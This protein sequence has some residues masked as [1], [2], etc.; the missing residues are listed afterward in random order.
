MKKVIIETFEFSE[1]SEEAQKYAIQ[2]YRDNMEVDLV[3]FDDQAE[4]KINHAGFENTKLQYR[5]SNS[6]GDGLSFSADGYTGLLDLI[7][8]KLGEGK[9][10]SAEAIYNY[11]GLTIKGNKGRYCYASEKDIELE[12]QYYNRDLANVEN[13]IECVEADIQDVYMNLCKELEKIGYEE[14]EYQ[15]S[16]EYIKET[17]L[18]SEYYMFTEDGKSYVNI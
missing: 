13:L 15:Y 7:K 12:F 11:C 18:D 4:E 9:G 2:K 3:G 1:L 6:Q 10:K 5:L 16:D 8:G 17:L 14:I